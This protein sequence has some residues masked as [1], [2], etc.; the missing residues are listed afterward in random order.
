MNSRRDRRRHNHFARHA[1][2]RQ[3][4][5]DADAVRFP[6]LPKR[7]AAC[8]EEIR[9]FAFSSSFRFVVEVTR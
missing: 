7:Y 2:D 4:M 1:A 5:V 8:Y 9:Y 6:G 3:T